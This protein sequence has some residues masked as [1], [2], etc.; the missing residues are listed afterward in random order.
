[1]VV[2]CK[3][4]CPANKLPPLFCPMLACRGGGLLWDSTVHVHERMVFL[5]QWKTLSTRT[6]Y[7]KIQRSATL[8][9]SLDLLASVLDCPIPILKY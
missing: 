4:H 2:T 1:M 5:I 6:Q 9:L 7:T 3:Y 8:T